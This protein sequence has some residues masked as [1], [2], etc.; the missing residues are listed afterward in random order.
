MKI[1]KNKTSIVQFLLV[2]ISCVVFY[3]TQANN[4]DTQTSSS[5]TLSIADIIQ[6][7]KSLNLFARSLKKSGINEL[8][9]G[10]G[11]Y[12]VF[13]SND[14]AYE[15]VSFSRKLA[16]WTN[17]KRMIRILNFH[18]VRGRITSEDLKTVTSLTT[19]E[20]AQL[21]V[22]NNGEKVDIAGIAKKDIYA[23]NG[24]IHVI[25]KVIVPPEK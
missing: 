6:A 21:S 14:E 17:K 1:M 16:V 4:L 3:S 19:L 15:E 7:D 10:E 12:T 5:V 20:G 2:I 25:D 8:L 23:S 9:Q 24:I 18:I 13:V 11:P 22:E